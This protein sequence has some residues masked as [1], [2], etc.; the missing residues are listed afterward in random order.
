MDEL[1]LLIQISRPV[2]LD[3]SVELI[4]QRVAVVFRVQF[5]NLKN[6]QKPVLINQQEE[7]RMQQEKRPA[8]VMR[9][10]NRVNLQRR[11]STSYLNE[12]R[13]SLLFPQ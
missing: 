11:N 2:S 4:L 9:A 10:A 5:T 7:D 8:E 13:P 6:R 12:T 3:V 1:L